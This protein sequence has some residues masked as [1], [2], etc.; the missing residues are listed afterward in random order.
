MKVYLVETVIFDEYIPHINVINISSTFE[1]AILF[2]KKSLADD[3]GRIEAN[4]VLQ[5][6]EEIIDSYH[7]EAW[8]IDR[9]TAQEWIDNCK[10]L[11]E[12]EAEESQEQLSCYDLQS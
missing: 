10:K 5:I 7:D 9:L 6:V 11:S 4:S 2:I 12:Y 1:N 3:K 8:V